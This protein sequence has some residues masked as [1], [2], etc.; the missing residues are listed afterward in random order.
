MR[1]LVV[2][3]LVLACSS[4]V[5]AQDKPVLEVP[6]ILSY[7]TAVYNPVR[8][9][10]DAVRSDDVTCNLSRFAVTQGILQASLFALKHTI[11]GPAAERPCL[12]CAHD[13]FPSGHAGN[14]VPG[15]GDAWDHGGWKGLALGLSSAAVTA[16][17]RIWANRHTTKQVLVGLAVGAAA[18]WAGRILVR[19]PS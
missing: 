2:L 15:I 3:M 13:G 5:S 9:F 19:C 4:P 18:E 8:A 10:Y 6:D 1:R 7:G 12:G 16:I 11:N 17:L 14:A